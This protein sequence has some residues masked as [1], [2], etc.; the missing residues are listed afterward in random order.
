MLAV[1][2]PGVEANVR[3]HVFD[4]E[5]SQT[6]SVWQNS[7][8][9]LTASSSASGALVFSG[10][11][12]PGDQ[13]AIIRAGTG[14][15][16]PGRPTG[17]VAT[18]S[19]LGCAEVSWNANPESDVVL[20]RLYWGGA[21]VP[22]SASAY[23]DSIDVADT[24]HTEC[25]L[26]DGTYYLAVRAMNAAGML[27]V[28]SLEVIASVSNGNAQPPLPPLFFTAAAGD[29]GCASLA[30]VPDG[31]P[32]VVGYVVDYGPASVEQ[33]QAAQYEHTIDVG[34]VTSFDVCALATGTHYFSVRARNHVGML[35]AYAA[36]RAVTIVTTAVLVTRFEAGL[37][38]FAV[39]LSWRVRADEPLRGFRLYRA[40]KARPEMVRPVGALYPPGASAAT[41]RDVRGATAYRYELV[42]VREDGS[43]LRAAP[44]SVTTPAFALHL[45]QNAPN[46]FNPS[47]TIA[48]IT[49]SSTH[50]RLTVYDTRGA[51]VTTLL[52]AQ[53]EAGWQLVRWDGTDAGG[54]A[55]ASG[56][57][58]YRL[59]ARGRALT[60]KMVIVK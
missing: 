34:G 16:P 59:Q 5:S 17:V 3:I 8:E 56:T 27:S 1:H 38:D 7:L 26:P 42:V 53:V 51:L 37:E 52:D 41:D 60:R 28:S 35:S 50:A 11:M 12:T 6:Y 48:F 14:A 20:Y 13:F 18:G 4:L 49:P 32:Q 58:F 10:T 46:P 40:E 57:Y 39:R 29:S 33:G 54:R 23:D 44:V 25:G 31:N 45:A 2:A 21:S 30:W 55:V 22:G 43:E 36:E 24:T 15:Q 47:T 9:I 19:D